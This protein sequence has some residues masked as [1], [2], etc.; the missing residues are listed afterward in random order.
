MR[1][2]ITVDVYTGSLRKAL[3][4]YAN[5]EVGQFLVMQP[6][7]YQRIMNVLPR[8]ILVSSI[9]SRSFS[10]STLLFHSDK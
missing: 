4:S 10:S 9:F 8:A 2:N 3:E 1:W 6:G 5:H 7:V